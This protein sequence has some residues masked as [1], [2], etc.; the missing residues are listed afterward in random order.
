MTPLD[1]AH[2][3]PDRMAFF[4]ALA[5]AELFLLLT[6]E[7]T[8]TAAGDQIEPQIFETEEGK[9]VLAF[10]REDRMAEFVGGTAAYAALSGRALAQMLSGQGIGLALNPEVAPS[11]ELLPAEALDWLAETLAEG[12]TEASAKPEEIAPPSAPEALITALDAK[13]AAAEGLAR[14]CYLVAATYQGGRRGHILAF[15]GA[16]PGAEPALAQAAHEALI[17]SGLEAG[18][19]DV[20]FFDA[21]DPMAA[22]LARHGL[23]FDLP[24]AAEPQ[25]IAAPPGMDPDRPPRLR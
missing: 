15:V 25:A 18:A 10:D 1:H 14:L 9:F 5:G 22:K 23:R 16:A 24:Q 6:Q 13:L 2:A 12:P 7:P 4:S 3:A 11:S 21:S 8:T 17:F 20:A 19:L